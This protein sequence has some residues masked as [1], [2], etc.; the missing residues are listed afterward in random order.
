MIVRF[1]ICKIRITVYLRKAT[2]I[3]MVG[4]CCDSIPIRVLSCAAL[5][6]AALEAGEEMKTLLVLRKETSSGD[7][8]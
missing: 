7:C 3:S 4:L 1:F 8:N 6:H 2:C 5:H